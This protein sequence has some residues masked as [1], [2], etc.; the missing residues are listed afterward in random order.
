M[1]GCRGGMWINRNRYEEL[2]GRSSG[3]LVLELRRQIAK[4]E[5]QLRLA[6]ERADREQLRADTALDV[7]GSTKGLAPVS[8]ATKPSTMDE[9]PH[10]EDAA[11]VESIR[12]DIIDRG[13]TEVLMSMK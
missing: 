11:E 2:I 4:L 3:E 12:R 5:D 1:S 7:V 9:D 6:L 10:A 8:P 13:P